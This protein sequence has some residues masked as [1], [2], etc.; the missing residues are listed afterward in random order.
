MAAKPIVIE[1]LLIT[2]RHIS[3]LIGLV[4]G[5]VSLVEQP[6]SSDV[7]YGEGRW[8]SFNSLTGRCGDSKF[9]RTTIEGVGKG[10][11]LSKKAPGQGRG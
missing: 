2:G 9:M 5:G 3:G 10:R 1:R 8:V 4:M 11:G 6:L 7:A